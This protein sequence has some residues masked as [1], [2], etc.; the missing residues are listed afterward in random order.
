MPLGE[1]NKGGLRKQEGKKPS[2]GMVSGSPTLSLVSRH[3]LEKNLYLGVGFYSLAQIIQSSV[4]L[5]EDGKGKVQ[6]P[7]H[8][9]P[10]LAS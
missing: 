9:R 8:F 5:A 6:T 3:I 1:T 10:A 4:L 7:G 2:R